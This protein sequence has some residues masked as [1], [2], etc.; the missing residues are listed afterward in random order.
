MNREQAGNIL[1]A[2]VSV[3]Y[4]LDADGNVDSDA[5][6]AKKSLREAILDAMTNVTYCP[7][8]VSSPK[9]TPLTIEPHKPYVTWTAENTASGSVCANGAG[10]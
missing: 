1:D 3:C 9:V 2:Y 4:A 10:E 6:K 7:L 5:K 8:T